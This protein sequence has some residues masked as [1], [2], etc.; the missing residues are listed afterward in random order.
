MFLFL[1]F[2]SQVQE[3]RF[4]KVNYESAVDWRL[5]TD[6]L[7]CNPSFHGHERRDCALIRTN[8]KDGNDKNI[9]VCILLMFKHTVGS[10]V[11]DL[12]LVLPMDLRMGPRR[13]ID[14]DLRLT[15][16]RARP[17]ASLEFITLH[18]IIRGVLVVPDFAIPG[19]YFLVNYVDTDIFLHS[20]RQLF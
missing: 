6:Y 12:A 3:H 5:A 8:D 4:L 19:D 13:T 9:F 14:R 16:L 17:M 18:S 20:Q 10:K 11:L 2:L 7:W 15:H 1:N